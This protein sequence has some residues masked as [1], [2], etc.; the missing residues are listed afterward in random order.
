MS[1]L[2]HSI[3]KTLAPQELLQEKSRALQRFTIGVL[4]ENKEEETRVALTPQGVAMLVD[5]GHKVLLE[6]G[7]GEEANFSDLDYTEHGGILVERDEALQQDIILKITPPDVEDIEK[8]KKR[9][10]VYSLMRY[11]D[12]CRERLAAMKAKNVTAVA[13][14]WVEGVQGECPMFLQPN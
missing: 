1:Q 4:K 6:R 2:T 14:D 3:Q 7:V 11:H 8:M 13:M 12:M 5:G 9:A 10:L